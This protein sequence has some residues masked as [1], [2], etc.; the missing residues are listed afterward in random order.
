MAGWPVERKLIL[1][2][3]Q[4]TIFQKTSF[5]ISADIKI[6]SDKRASCFVDINGKDKFSTIL[7]ILKPDKKI[8]FPLLMAIG[9]VCYYGRSVNGTHQICRFVALRVSS[10]GEQKYE[11]K[12][13]A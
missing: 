6:V 11:I 9:A 5:Y 2:I 4:E 8:I 3:F 10:K 12:T 1:E 7:D 13:N